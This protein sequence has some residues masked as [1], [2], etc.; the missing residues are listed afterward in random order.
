VATT[1]MGLARCREYDPEVFFVRG[2]SK[3]RR[4]IRVCQRCEVREQCLAY[5]VENEIEFGVWGGLTERQRRRL[6]RSSAA[7]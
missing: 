4:A 3:S 5:A 6:V 1:W 2:A 7:S